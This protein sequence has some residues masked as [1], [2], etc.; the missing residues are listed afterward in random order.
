MANVKISELPISAPLTGFELL[1]IVQS[2]ATKKTMLSDIISFGNTI[3][4]TKTGAEIT[5]ASGL[6]EFEEIIYSPSA[7]PNDWPILMFYN[8]A[9]S[10]DF[11]QTSS[12]S[13]TV[14]D[15][16]Y[17][18]ADEFTF[19]KIGRQS[20]AGHSAYLNITLEQFDPDA[21]TGGDDTAAWQQAVALSNSTGYGIQLLA[22]TYLID[23]VSTAGPYYQIKSCLVG[24]GM[25]QS[26]IKLRTPL[27]DAKTGFLLPFTGLDGVRFE[28]FNYD[29]SLS[30]DPVDWAANYDNFQGSRGLFLFDCDR[31]SI[32]RVLA[33]N[34]MQ[35]GFALYN[36]RGA[37]VQHCFTN[38][39]RGNFG[40][41]FYLTGKDILVENCYAY[42]F[43]RIGYVLETNAEQP[44]LTRNAQFNNC[45]A[46]Y[47]HHRSSLY[48]GVEGN[49]GFWFENYIQ[50]SCYR[51]SAIRP[52]NDAGFIVANS[53]RPDLAAEMANI[54]YTETTFDTCFVDGGEQGLAY[55]FKIDSLNNTL[56]PTVNIR[57]C[58]G[59]DSGIF[60]V[61]APHADNRTLTVVEN[62]H[63]VLTSVQV[64]QVTA[65][66]AMHLGG[67]M[68]INNSSIWYKAF[69]Q[70]LWDSGLDSYA[71]VNEF[72]SDAGFKLTIDNLKAFAPDR[73]ERPIK[74][75]LGNSQS[76]SRRVLNVTNCL[77]EE[78]ENF[79][80]EAY[81]DKC[82]YAKLGTTV[83][84][85]L[86]ITNSTV[87]DTQGAGLGRR[88]VAYGRVGSE[89]SI[90]NVLFDFVE[91]GGYLY[92]YNIANETDEPNVKIKDCTF[93]KD[94]T[95]DGYMI[96]IN[97][98]TEI[99]DTADIHNYNAS[100]THFI[101]IGGS[102]DNPIVFSDLSGTVNPTLYGVGNYKSPTLTVDAGANVIANF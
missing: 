67:E 23:A 7:A 46:K 26:K 27:S 13:A 41:A 95:N 75:K 87:L 63:C 1:P 42:D 50:A 85:K 84:D 92:L 96:R 38:R 36:V 11:D 2:G 72:A 54:L 69:N 48:G 65:C 39:T 100:G 37:H 102:T 47:A 8:G 19:I 43:T 33:S 86:S 59:I 6:F 61:N 31:I 32:S 89:I 53:Y 79:I 57:N 80:K 15:I 78:D 24:V 16:G 60:I 68:V 83:A 94:V 66:F 81:F 98:A 14:T 22:K 99:T 20:G 70:T 28:D 35:A 17:A 64:N 97:A 56:R 76:L 9:L 40:D 74:L 3:A 62:S 82:T 10:F 5:A 73:S 25:M 44:Y 91:S 30:A 55:G 58:T 77:I 45:V 90:E 88:P 29:C 4:E 71:V 51:C 12:T 52:G 18:P 21:G 101:N 34:V 49:T 93:K